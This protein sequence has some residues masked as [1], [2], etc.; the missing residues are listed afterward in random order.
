MYC[1]SKR[2]GRLAQI[3]T[4]LLAA[5][6]LIAGYEQPQAQTALEG[7]VIEGATLSGDPVN[8]STVG[9][10]V[11]VVTSADLERRQIRNAADA[12][13]TVPGVIVGRTGSVGGVT[14][15]RIRGGEGNQ[16][17]VVIDGVDVRSLE[18]GEFD[19][20]TLLATDIERIEVIRG[21]QSGIY[22]ANALTGV[23]NIVTKK[24]GV[25]RVGATA[26]GGSFGSSY[27]AANASAGT[28]QAHLSLSAAHK[29]TDGFNVSRTGP[30]RDGSEQKTFFA[31]GG[32]SLT[33]D[34]RI[35]AMGRYQTNF[36]ESDRGAPVDTLG[37]TDAREQMF[38]SVFAEV[39]TFQK[40]WT[41]RLFADHL[42]D[43]F[44]SITAGSIFS[45]F[46][47]FGERTRYGYLSTLT[48]ATNAGLAAEHK[49]VGLA[50]RIREQSE[51]S[52]QTRTAERAQD[53]FALEYRGGFADRFFL[54]ANVRHDDKD[55][56]DDAT[57]YR[58]SAAYLL[59]ETGTRVHA[60]YGKGITDPTFFELFGRTTDFAGNPDLQPEE[61]IGWDIGVE[62][63]LLNDRL[64]FDVTYFQSDLTKQISGFSFGGFT[65]VQNNP[66]T[67]ER[68][69]VEVTA[70]AQ[71]T[72]DLL[73]SGAYTYT[74]AKTAAGVGEVRRPQHSGSLSVTY[75]FD[76]GRGKVSAD[77]IYNGEMT[78]NCFSPLCGFSPVPVALDEYLVVNLAAS[79]KLTDQIEA[80]GRVENLFD[81]N[82][83][84]VF[85]FETAPVAVYAGLRFSL[86]QNE[87]PAE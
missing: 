30:E 15:V 57:T 46:T 28:E 29:K 52:S 55:A 79:Y 56:F 3:T 1:V 70:S 73:V 20:S 25:P 87:Q 61:A 32:A 36:T 39:D 26:E 35:G 17:K 67:S 13:R 59:P 68:R 54:T 23:I 47:S 86:G 43:D 2:G 72:P 31:R 45:P 77:A 84:E 44:T 14:Q 10:S 33:D 41:H 80:F 78:D 19:F 7:I 40:A 4:G 22:G 42:D 74:D 50:E 18:G 66:G 75:S 69:G 38:G 65:S 62:Q 51:L 63:K 76:D 9:S 12:L 48:F 27:F 58:L 8:P 11:S 24:G 64:I 49:I 85:G 5:T 16:V 71:L 34:I 21:P 37:A 82:Y 6:A 83:E 81:E 60:S 53:A